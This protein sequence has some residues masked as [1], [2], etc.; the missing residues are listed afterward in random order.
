MDMRAMMMMAGLSTFPLA[1]SAGDAGDD[2]GPDPSDSAN[3]PDQAA[4][5]DLAELQDRANGQYIVTL[6]DPDATGTAWVEAHGVTAE[7][8]FDHSVRGCVL[9]G[10]PEMAEELRDDPRSP[11]SS[12]TWSSRS[13]PAPTPA[14]T[15]SR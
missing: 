15:T 5:D 10:S 2:R 1:C 6:R 9:R 4:G 11:P 13:A 7:R 3:P 12:R 14:T 8:V